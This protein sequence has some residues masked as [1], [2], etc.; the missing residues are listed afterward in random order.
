MDANEAVQKLETI[1]EYAIDLVFDGWHT[2]DSLC[3]EIRMSVEAE[4]NDS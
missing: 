4:K 2:I 1:N 3:D